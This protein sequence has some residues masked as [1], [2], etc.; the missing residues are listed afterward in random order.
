MG[1]I[2]SGKGTVGD[3]LKDTYGFQSHSFAASLKDAVSVIFNWPR[4]LLEGDTKESREFREVEDKFWTER[5][6]YSITP[7][8]IL[9]RFGTESCRDVLGEAIWTSSLETRLHKVLPNVVTD[10]RFPNEMEMIKSI[11]GFICWVE[12]GDRPE[13]YQTA[14]DGNFSHKMIKHPMEII[15]PDIH[16][17]EWAWIGQPVDYH[18]KNDGTLE[19]LHNSVAKMIEESYIETSINEGA[20]KELYNAIDPKDFGPPK[21][22]LRN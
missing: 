11:G 6:G 22:F 13:W 4:H 10:V 18:I 3:I 17:S 8:L 14:L 20:L 19:E 5:L 2:G 1:L 7:R 15:Y 12:R 21:E 9:Q 16:R